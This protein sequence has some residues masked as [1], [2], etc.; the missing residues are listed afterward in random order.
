[1][2]TVT[3]ILPHGPHPGIVSLQHFGRIVDSFYSHHAKKK[4]RHMARIASSLLVKAAKLTIHVQHQHI[5]G[6]NNPEA[7]CLNCLKNGWHM[8]S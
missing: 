1:M 8:P 2:G 4:Y 3:P 6:A 5:A 7:D